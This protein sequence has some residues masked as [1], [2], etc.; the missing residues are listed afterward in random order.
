M[1][2]S[3]L[4]ALARVARVYE[5]SDGDATKA[6]YLELEALGPAGVVALN[7]FR[8][9]KASERAKEY[10]RGYSR[11]AYEKKSWSLGN[12]CQALEREAAGLGVGWG[13]GLD[14]AAIHF[15]HVLYV[16]L[17]TGQVSFHGPVRGP[18]PEHPTGFDGK[19]KVGPDRVIRFCAQLLSAGANDHAVGRGR[20]GD[21]ATT[22]QLVALFGLGSAAEL[23]ELESAAAGLGIIRTCAGAWCRNRL[24]SWDFVEDKE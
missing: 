1:S 16:D 6:L 24:G 19:K 22:A 23:A 18:G 14:P 15:E 12:L 21:T 11:M 5:G 20:N 10:R 3:Y 13:W 2:A 7:L 8:A 4:E 17:P 9:T